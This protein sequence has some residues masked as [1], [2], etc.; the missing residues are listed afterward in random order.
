MQSVDLLSPDG[1]SDALRRRLVAPSSKL[2]GERWAGNPSVLLL[3]ASL[4]ENA[5]LSDTDPLHTVEAILAAGA[6][7][8]GHALAYAAQQGNSGCVSVLLR[9]GANPD[10]K[11]GAIPLHLAISSRARQARAIVSELL[12]HGAKP[13]KR[14]GLGQTSLHLAVFRGSLD[15]ADEL[16][17]SDERLADLA[18]GCG[19]T[20]LRYAALAGRQP[21]VRYLAACKNLLPK[22]CARLST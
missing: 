22:K 12:A 7:P 18:D 3:G 5:C 20:A 10:G 1:V 2:S 21:M 16:I 17:G 4:L 8:S 13:S 14:N 9:H 15:L 11:A 6:R 19:M